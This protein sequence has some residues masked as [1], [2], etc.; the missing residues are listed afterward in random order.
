MFPA[1][2]CWAAARVLDGTATPLTAL[3]SCDGL[4]P[5]LPRSCPKRAVH[6]LRQPSDLAGVPP[7]PNC[8]SNDPRRPTARP[9][10]QPGRPKA[11]VIPPTRDGAGRAFASFDSTSTLV[12]TAGTLDHAPGPD[13]GTAEPG[14]PITRDGDLAATSAVSKRKRLSRRF[15][16]Q[17]GVSPMTLAHRTTA[18]RGPA[19]TAR[20]RTVSPSDRG[21]RLKPGSAPAVPRWARTL[22]GAGPRLAEGLPENTFRGTP[23]DPSG[24]RSTRATTA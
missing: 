20:R 10:R 2:S 24:S 22:S 16:R 21:R 7:D 17:R 15:A 19:K 5:A 1:R 6:R 3:Q 12:P 11:T 13:L 23:R 8:A 18:A 14:P 4:P 9:C